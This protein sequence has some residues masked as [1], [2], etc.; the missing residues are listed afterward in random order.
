VPSQRTVG[1]YLREAR[2]VPAEEQRRYREA[3]WPASFGGADLPW[4]S[5]ALLREVVDFIGHRPLARNLTWLWRTTLARPDRSLLERWRVAGWLALAEA[6]PDRR[7]AA[8]LA[9]DSHGQP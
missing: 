7:D 9:E 8:Q 4:Q 3:S 5:A 2:R 1:N 6:R